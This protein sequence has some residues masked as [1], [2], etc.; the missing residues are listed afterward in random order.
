MKTDEVCDRPLE[1]FGA[2]LHSWFFIVALIVCVPFVP[3]ATTKIKL[4]GSV[5][6]EGVKGA[7][8][9]PPCRLR[10][11]ETPASHTKSLAKGKTSYSPNLMMEERFST[12][13]LA[14]HGLFIV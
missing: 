8:G 1:T 13:A 5:R 2:L 9:K 6:A 3:Q 14:I 12:I 7:T 11:G 4:H 10:R